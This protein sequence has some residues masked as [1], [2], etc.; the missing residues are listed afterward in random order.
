MPY[1][2]LIHKAAA[3][4][5]KVHELDT[6]K[7]RKGKDI[8]Y[9]THPLTVGLIVARVTE[10]DNIVAA[11]ILHDTIEDCEPY[12]SVTQELL[13][14]EFNVDVARIVNDVSEPDRASTWAERKQQALE[15][16]QHLQ[17]DSQLVKSAD[18]LHNLL[19]LN[20][21]LEKEGPLV[22]ERF[23]ASKEEIVQRYQKL[24][25]E[26]KRLWPENPLIEDLT[27]ALEK[28]LKLTR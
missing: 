4:A 7:K 12:G 2:P 23:N 17:H 28:L 25:P 10:N 11:G 3:F 19:E 1:T 6:K 9:I 13:T 27:I 20:D 16:L 8:P 14:T 26:I 24:I 21:D 5:I 22:F 18:V 15:H